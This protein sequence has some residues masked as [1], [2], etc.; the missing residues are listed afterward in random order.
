MAPA[1]QDSLLSYA[2]AVVLGGALLTTACKR[3]WPGDLGPWLLV[4][5]GLVLALAGDTA[6]GAPLQQQALL[7]YDP[8]S[9]A[10]YYGIGNEYMGVLIG[11]ALL[12]GGAAL[13]LIGRRWGWVL[14][15]AAWLA[16]LFFLAIP[17]YG[18]YVGGTMAAGAAFGLALLL[19][20]RVR[21]SWTHVLAVGAA[22]AALVMAMGWWDGSR[23]LA[24][25]SHLGRAVALV[26][27]EG[28]GAAQ[29]IIGRKLATNLRL[30]RYTI[31]TRVLLSGLVV[32]T[33]LLHYPVGK[34]G[35]FCRCYSRLSRCL[36]AMV[37]GSF[38]A[39]VFNDSGIVAAATMM[40]YGIG[41]FLTLILAHK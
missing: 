13:E 24:V 11:A 2:A 15:T 34:M 20:W 9:G 23:S 40:I 32:L 36:L 1:R 27:H 14:A 4:G 19:L 10:R 26:R 22:A 12:T 25:Q 3:F 33:V 39:L 37:A 30:I 35:E 17:G 6:V 5:A 28:W 41:P 38:V 16:S 18:A 7:S 31:W 29:E 8:V 21:L